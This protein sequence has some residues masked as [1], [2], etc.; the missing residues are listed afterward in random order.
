MKKVFITLLIVGIVAAL[1]F[2]LIKALFKDNGGQAVD[3][4]NTSPTQSISQEEINQAIEEIKP[5]ESFPSF[6]KEP[7]KFD[8]SKT[9]FGTIP[10][11]PDSAKPRTGILVN[12]DD[13]KV[14]WAKAP[15]KPVPIASMT[16]MMTALLAFED[17]K[18]RDDL[19]FDTVVQITKTAAGI[20]GSQLYLDPRESFTFGE[21]LKAVMIMSANDASQQIAEFLGNGDVSQF[22]ARM[23][24]RA[25][26]LN[27]PHSRFLNPHGLPGKTAEEDNTSTAEAMVILAVELLSYPQAVEWA[28]T[29]I[30]FLKRKDLKNPGQEKEPT[31]MRNHNK[32]IGVCPGVNGMKTGFTQRAKFCVTATCER[33]GRRLSAVVTGFD[34]QKERDAFVAKLLDWGYK[35]ASQTNDLTSA[36]IPNLPFSDVVPK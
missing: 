5:A 29:K 23:N 30:D 11:L 25:K 16:K 24:A 17:E 35:K 31:M 19:N 15:R 27:M 3:G 18:K 2:F 26:E 12:I 6:I 13:G 21:L 1:H 10:E 7:L 20:G 36:D 4:Q 22:V 33:G 28:S 32:L 9:L 14:Y 34:T 8:Y